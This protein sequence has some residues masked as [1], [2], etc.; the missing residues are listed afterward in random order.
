MRRA[1]FTILA[2]FQL[3]LVYSQSNSDAGFS[4][5]TNDSCIEEYG[6][7]EV[8]RIIEIPPILS[9]ESE[10]QLNR[11][12]SEILRKLEITLDHTLTVKLVIT[13][14]SDGN[15]CLR[16]VGFTEEKTD[17]FDATNLFK[18][19]SWFDNFSPGSQ[20]QEKRHCQS[21]INLE[22]KK[23]KLKSYDYYNL[24]IKI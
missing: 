14:Y 18:Q 15:W 6:R 24:I 10:E 8:F 11:L 21:S 17:R 16:K 22:I 1:I 9:F 4:F 7:I 12:F 23:G 20:R 13:F 3:S 5:V 2:I 19:Q